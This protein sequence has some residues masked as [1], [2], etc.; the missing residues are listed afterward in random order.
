MSAYLFKTIV[1]SVDIPTVSAM[2]L[3][4][5]T[6]AGFLE[7]KRPGI[8]FYMSQYQTILLCS[9]FTV[10]LFSRVVSTIFYRL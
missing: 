2:E 1:G 9:A 5:Y 6:K 10:I 4:N 3:V 8:I 7:K